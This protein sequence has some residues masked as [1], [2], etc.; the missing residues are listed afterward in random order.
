MT[1]GPDL[2]TRVSILEEKVRLISIVLKWL[3]AGLITSLVAFI[4]EM[5]RGP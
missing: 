5:S 4:F 3:V 1:D 2:A